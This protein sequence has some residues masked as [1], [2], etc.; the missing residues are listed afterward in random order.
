VGALLIKELWPV[1]WAIGMA[2]IPRGEVGLIFAELGRESGIFNNEIY[3]GMVIVIAFTTLLP[4][5]AMKLFYV[6]YADRMQTE[7][8]MDGEV[9]RTGI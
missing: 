1:R 8:L 4:P 2:M 5:F 7:Q 3:A 9:K 6:R